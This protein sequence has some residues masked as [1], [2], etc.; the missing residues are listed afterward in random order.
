MNIKLGDTVRFLNAMGGGV[1]T[2]ID[3]KKGLVYVEDAD[4]FEIPT[5]ERD[6][7]VVPV[8][9]EKT[10]FPV[11]D[12]SSK[13][14]AAGAHQPVPVAVAAPKPQ[15][16]VETA[17]GDT[18]NALLAFFPVEIKQLQTTPYDC[19]LV[20]DSN[21]F[22]YY[23]LI[24]GED[25]QMKSVANGLIEPNMQEELCSITKEQLNSWESLRVQLIPFKQNKV[26]APQDVLDVELKINVV[27]FYKLHSFTDN[28]Y[29][30]EPCIL[31][32]LVAE[33]EKSALAHI[34][35][36]DIK[37]AMY[38]KQEPAKPKAVRR[39]EQRVGNVLEVDLHIN[40][41]VDTTAGMSNADMLLLQMDK[42]Y[43]IL[44]EYKNKKGQK[45]V[46]IH[47]KGE[48]VLRKEIEKQLKT[49]YKTHYF[50]DAS[51]RE[52]GFGATMVT[53]K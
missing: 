9:N 20:N 28:E 50:Q 10:N 16:V 19:Y 31:I 42:F 34:S 3:A 24:N 8:V 21:Y 1:V 30:D 18:L 14:A 32:D 25:G 17:E 46:F 29:F 7:V 51:F 27:K 2:K 11:K 6:C 38:D 15:A 5:L 33:K 22:L 44:E 39:A 4:G 13:P 37:S 45:I 41:L 40:E 23:N 52:Y 48:G 36:E 26:Y 47:G 35:P 12:F 49:R 53:I 43:A